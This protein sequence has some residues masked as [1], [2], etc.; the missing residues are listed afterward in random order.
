MENKKFLDIII[1]FMKEAGEIA[2][3]YQKNLSASIKKDESIVTEADLTISKLFREKINDFIVNNNHKILDEENLPNIQELFSN[4]TEYLWTIDPIDGTTTYYHGLPLWAIGISLYKNL[5]PYISAIYMPKTRELVYTNGTK[6]YFIEE[7]FTNKENITIL[8]SK[9]K[10]LTKKSIILQHKLKNFDNLKY[11]T[12]DLYSSY[13]LGLYTLIGR[14][15][16]CFFNKPMK[17]WDITATLP[18][19]HNLGMVFKNVKNGAN[20]EKLEMETIDDEWYIKDTYIMCN[21]GNCEEI[22]N[23]I[24]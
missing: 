12:L 5:K 22:L 7:S 15:A 9:P 21:K 19:A 13:V 6:S 10:T 23:L 8:E 11:T 24:L 1:S 17:L 16:A 18:I 2:I 3:E 20:L 14:S 4:K